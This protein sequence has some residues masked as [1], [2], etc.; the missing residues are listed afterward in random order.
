MAATVAG[1]IATSVN[2]GRRARPMSGLLL[3]V[4]YGSYTNIVTWR[5]SDLLYGR[6][7]GGRNPERDVARVRVVAG[8]GARL[9]TTKTKHKHK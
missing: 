6:L 7:R 5:E 8:V 4:V 1:D 3:L 2:K 9:M